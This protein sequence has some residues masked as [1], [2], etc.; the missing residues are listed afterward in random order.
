M[1]KF[2]NLDSISDVFGKN[3][4]VPNFCKDKSD[5]CP[6]GRHQ[7]LANL[8]CTYSINEIQDNS[9]TIDDGKYVYRV[10]VF[11]EKWRK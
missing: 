11:N 4:V 10:V 1:I 6:I 8:L 5:N 7:K 3:A 9:S 2:Q